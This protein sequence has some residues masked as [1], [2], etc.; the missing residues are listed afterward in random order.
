MNTEA[1]S[2]HPP[3]AE[4]RFGH[5]KLTNEKLRQELA[6]VALLAI[7]IYAYG[8]QDNDRFL[9]KTE[10]NKK[11]SP[12]A[13]LLQLIYEALNPDVRATSETQHNYQIH[14]GD[15]FNDDWL[16]NWAK[17]RPHEQAYFDAFTGYTGPRPNSKPEFVP[18]STMSEKQ[19]G[20]ELPNLDFNDRIRPWG[21]SRPTEEDFAAADRANARYR[22]ALIKRG[23]RGGEVTDEQRKGARTDIMRDLH[24]D[25]SNGESADAGALNVINGHFDYLKRESAKKTHTESPFKASEGAASDFTP[26]ETSE[27]SRPETSFN[28]EPAGTPQERHDSPLEL[29]AA[30]E[31]SPAEHSNGESSS[32]S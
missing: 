20:P 4:H 1:F 11:Q 14:S 5:E 9:P 22:D 18:A 30:P 10:Q 32:T 6:K 21:V 17:P 31:H 8:S 15:T 24:P 7:L 27:D 23:W 3:T 25:H 26:N 29:T 2:Q 16:D 12:E 13:E 19:Y 28:T